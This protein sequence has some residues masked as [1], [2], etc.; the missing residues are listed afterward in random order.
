MTVMR[1]VRP[2]LA[3][4]ALLASGVPGLAEAP[5]LRSEVIV[6]SDYVRLGDLIEDAGAAA[7]EA[8]FRSPDL[9]TVGTVQAS[10]VLAAAREKGLAG[11]D[12]L[13]LAEVSVK[14]ASRT[15]SIDEMKR[16]LTLAIVRNNGL[17]DDS[18]ISVNFDSGVRPVHVEPGLET[19]L[20]VTQ[21]VWSPA[22]GRF[23]VTFGIEGSN[24]LGR[25]PLRATG[26][27]VE[28]LSVPVFTRQLN[29]GEIIRAS[30]VA[31]ERMPRNAAAMAAVSGPE[32]AIGQAARRIVRPGQ[33]VTPADLAKPDLVSRNDAVTL[34]YEVPGVIL[35][36][37]AKA[38]G[39]GAMGDVVAVLN[40]QSNRVVQATVT[41]PGR[42]VVVA[43]GR[44]ASN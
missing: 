19:P 2:L 36:I 25:R 14:R 7:R 16:A 31:L 10:R 38:I 24:V 6:S 12:T 13:G 26:T 4:V 33:A 20:Q 32:A 29:R 27:G 17:G 3:A 42:V 37:R 44:V 5:R 1:A 35:T 23:D 41:G 9:G 30:D 8:V 22:S 15:V 34:V 18:D 39:T 28:T 43:P 11:V 21:L 40:P